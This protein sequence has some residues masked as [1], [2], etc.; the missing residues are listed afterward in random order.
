MDDIE[1]IFAHLPP[2]Q[3]RKELKD[4]DVSRFLFFAVKVMHCLNFRPIE[5]TEDNPDDWQAVIDEDH[6]EPATNLDITRS[7]MLDDAIKELQSIYGTK[8][9][10]GIVKKLRDMDQDPEIRH[11]LTDNDRKAIKRLYDSIDE[12]CERA[13]LE[14][15]ITDASPKPKSTD[16]AKENKK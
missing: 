6:R 7:D 3:L 2:D 12:Y 4:R 8:N 16:E 11:R 15:G 5:G 14:Y 10:I 9:P 13:F 1:M